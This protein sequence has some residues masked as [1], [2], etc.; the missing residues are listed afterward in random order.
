V[1]LPTPSLEIERLGY[2]QLVPAGEAEHDRVVKIC[3]YCGREN[4]S[5]LT[6]CGQCG[7]ELA[8]RQGGVVR[9]KPKPAVV[10]P[11]CGVADDYKAAIALRGSFNWAVF[12]LGGFLAVIFH[13]AS[14]QQRVQ[15]N[16]CGGFFGIRSPISR[17]SLVIFW[18]LVAP[19]VLVL[20][21]VLISALFLR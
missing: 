13:N 12:F 1:V 20:L 11:A 21:L 18:L 17:I 9:S 8:E 19:S 6:H 4:G 3:S 16:A 14:H 15:C 10:C 2:F 5:N 7:M